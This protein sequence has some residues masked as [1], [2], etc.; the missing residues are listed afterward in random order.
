MAVAFHSRCGDRVTLI[1]SNRTAVRNF[2][3][4]NNGLVLSSQPLADNQLFQVR[5]DKKIN[6]WS[7][8]IEIGV[9][10]LNPETMEF[11]STAS[12]L[13]GGSWI[14][15]GT[16]VLK[17]GQSIVEVYGEDLEK[18]SEGDCVGVMRTSEGELVFYVNEESQGVA[19]RDVPSGVYGFVDMYGKCAQVTVID[20]DDETR[21][22]SDDRSDFDVELSASCGTYEPADGQQQPALVTDLVVNMNVANTRR[23]VIAF[24]EESPPASVVAAEDVEVSPP[25]DRLRFHERCGSL[26]RISC[27][28]RSAERR[29][30][31]DEFNNGVVMTHRPLHDDELF[32]IRID[33]LVDKWSGSIEVGVTTHDPAALAFPATMT[34]LRTGTTMMSGSGIL[35]N[36]KGTRREYGEFNLD[37]LWEGDRIGMVR[38]AN[39]NL[40]YFING[41]DQGVA[42]SKVPSRVWGVVDLYGMTV[43]VSIVDRDER[44][45]QN[46]ITRRNT[47]QRSQAALHSLNDLPE[48][49]NVDRLMFHPNCGTHAAVINNHRTAHR[50]H[51]MD[52]FNNGVVLTNRPL[53]PGELFEVR[54]DKMVTKWAGSIEIGVT[55]HSPAELEFPST[56]TNVRSGTW[57][58]TG[59]GVMH[60][61]STVIHEYGQNL[62]RLQVGDR[63]GVMRTE[64]GTL[65][66]FVNGVDQ[67]SAG[68]GVPEQVYGVIDLYGQAVQATIVDPALEHMCRSASD[69]TFSTTNRTD[70]AAAGDGDGTASYSD[71]RFRH[72]HGKKA[73]LSNGGTTASRPR[74]FGEFNDAILVSN[75]PLRDDEIFEVVVE[76]TV[77][78]WLGS[79]EAG[80]TSVRPDELEL[81]CTMTDLEH[82]TWML[83]GSNVMVDGVVLRKD[84]PCD[85]DEVVVGNRV[86]MARHS[87]GTLHFYLDGVDRGAAC[88]GVPPG[89]YAVIDLYGQCA[90]VS[91]VQPE[92]PA[93]AAAGAAPGRLALPDRPHQLTTETTPTT[94]GGGNASETL[95]PSSQTAVPADSCHRFGAVSGKNVVLRSGGTVATRLRGYSHALVFS[96]DPL[97]PD[98]TFEICLRELA[99]HW[100]GTVRL[101]VTTLLPTMSASGSGSGS[102]SGGPGCPPVAA[103]PAVSADT[104]YL[105]RNEVQKNGR[106]L[107]H[108]YCPSLEWLTVGDRVGVRRAADGALSFSLN[109]EDVGVA[110]PY[111]P[112]KVYAVVDLYGKAVSVAVTSVGG[113]AGAVPTSPGPV[114]VP[115]LAAGSGGPDDSLRSSRLHDSLEILLDT[116]EPAQPAAD[117]APLEPTGSEGDTCEDVPVV[118]EAAADD[119]AAEL[120]VGAAPPEDRSERTKGSGGVSS[121]DKGQLSSRQGQ[122]DAEA[123]SLMS[124]WSERF[125][126]N[127]E[128]G[129]GGR[130]ARRTASYNQGLVV[131]DRQLPRDHVFQVRIEATD[132]RWVS[133]LL[134]GVTAALQPP[135]PPSPTSTPAAGPPP[136]PVPGPSSAPTPPPLPPRPAAPQ[137]STHLPVTALG[138]GKDTWVICGDFVLRNGIPIRGQYGPN[139]DSLGVGDVV[140]V[141][142]DAAGRLHLWVNGADQGVAAQDLPA[143]LHALVD[144]Y[145]QCQQVRVVGGPG[146]SATPDEAPALPLGTEEDDGA[147]AVA[148]AEQAGVGPPAACQA[149]QV[150]PAAYVAEVDD[151][152]DRDGL[153]EKADLECDEK[154]KVEA[155]AEAKRGAGTQR[156]EELF[157]SGRDPPASLSN[158]RAPASP[159]R[160]LPATLSDNDVANG[161]LKQQQQQQQQLHGSAP[162]IT[163]TAVAKKSA[164]PSPVSDNSVSQQQQQQ[165]HGKIVTQVSGGTASRRATPASTPGGGGLDSWAAGTP[166]AGTPAASAAAPASASCPSSGGGRLCASATAPPAA[167]AAPARKCDYHTVCARFRS[168]LGLPD[169]FFLPG[170]AGSCFCEQ[171]VRRL[172]PPS[173]PPGLTV[174]RKS[175]VAAAPAAASAA[176]T[177]T[178][179]SDPAIP[180]APS[181]VGTGTVDT[182]SG[183]AVADVAALQS[184]EILLQIAGWC[185]FPLKRRPK[186][187]PQEGGDS[188]GAPPQPCA[189]WHVAFWGARLGDVRQVLDRGELLLPGELGL[190]RMRDKS[191]SE[192]SQLVFSPDIRHA[193]SKTLP[194]RKK[195]EFLDPKT[196]QRYRA[197]AAFQVLVQPGTYKVSAARAPAQAEA[198]EWVTK[199]RGTTVLSALLL[200]LRPADDDAAPATSAECRG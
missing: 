183:P 191:D 111:V 104:W 127:I 86:G 156:D 129:P 97:E 155:Q 18:L 195:S 167:P 117:R 46:L 109:G 119:G 8:S 165:Q 102:G 107:Q 79:I 101:G 59:N 85:L 65:H 135:P 58:M 164:P 54:L 4:F 121:S 181:V 188:A 64:E 175:C 44:E 2:S 15:S 42:A 161:Q 41:L 96:S 130:T 184:A 172:R 95:G 138:L 140:G 89:V 131:S 25:P 197:W 38:K 150:A 158:A 74:A 67:G 68:A 139:L 178:G 66:F 151:A 147:E 149:A 125:G 105:I 24:E 3:E 73:R 62:D 19:A 30:P 7:G 51:A 22:D 137:R 143:H 166:P 32:E 190:Q 90:Q 198:E 6:S 112:K 144:V 118:R 48:E 61:G 108:C 163:P 103:L 14:L 37:E 182:G 55:M 120:A 26:V 70:A 83:S 192:G 77:D 29:R 169:G 134:V 114:G 196:R 36:G 1:N 100:S 168:F 193:V 39:G 136:G 50:P 186:P 81:P 78:C 80:V 69:T 154:E 152:E 159:P 142:V 194:C 124:F 153:S 13:R 132:P 92:R 126:R 35:T 171:C 170:D 45:E 71:L 57:M 34:N 52:D 87:D 185:R 75:R 187:S 82:G 21:G 11:P 20:D 200:R 141:S 145:G 94:V 84:Y 27:G 49:D 110:V 128:L 180:A 122:S 106:T 9:T 10:C 157:A 133:S 28:G 12:E 177:P 63:V 88:G 76:K 123:E 146:E 31:L 93:G 43:K 99:P 56:M 40:H 176:G 91:I 47:T 33:R 116:A 60:N 23:D 113:R 98:E 72:S 173:P 16:S 5:I 179:A 174:R 17:D 148:A 162:V 199:E 53:R 189:G 115:P 160:S